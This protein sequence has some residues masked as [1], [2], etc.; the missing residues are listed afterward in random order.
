LRL[1]FIA[2][3][4]LVGCSSIPVETQE[5]VKKHIYN[6]CMLDAVVFMDALEDSLEDALEA[7][8]KLDGS[9]IW[10]KTLIVTWQERNGEY[11]CHAYSVF[12]W[13]PGQN[14]LWAYDARGS[15]PIRAWKDDPSDVG[16]KLVPFLTD[17]YYVEDQP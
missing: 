6:G 17:A 11:G 16:R 9:S 7:K 12:M 5:K 3:A 15:Q 1:I 8:N 14:K 4:L 13:P 2:C 10:H